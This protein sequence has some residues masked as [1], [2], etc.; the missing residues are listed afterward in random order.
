MTVNDFHLVSSFAYNTEQGF[1]TASRQKGDKEF[2]SSL[3]EK[4]NLDVEDV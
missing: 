3:K 1:L 2:I 4:Y